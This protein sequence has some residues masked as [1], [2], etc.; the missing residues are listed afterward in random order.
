MSLTTEDIK[1][2]NALKQFNKEFFKVEFNSDDSTLT[3]T[4]NGTRRNYIEIKNAEKAF[5]EVLELVKNF[6]IDQRS[7]GFDIKADEIK[8]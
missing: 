4:V 7:E 1:R 3:L 6:F 8:N 2:I 5:D